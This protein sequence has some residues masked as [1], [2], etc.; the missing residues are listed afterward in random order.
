MDSSR[1]LL[2]GARPKQ[3]ILRGRGRIE[4]AALGDLR[5]RGSPASVTVLVQ[6]I[7]WHSGVIPGVCVR[8]SYS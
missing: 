8:L 1:I 5:Q 7:T 3:A 4:A 6:Q 2:V